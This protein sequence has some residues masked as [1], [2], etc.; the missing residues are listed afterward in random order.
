MKIRNI[1]P[2]SVI[3]INK[4][5]QNGGFLN[6][7]YT[8]ESGMT[9][10]AVGK[11]EK[12]SGDVNA[13]EEDWNNFLDMLGETAMPDS[14]LQELELKASKEVDE[15]VTGITLEMAAHPE[16]AIELAGELGKITSN[17]AK[18][19]ENYLDKAKKEASAAAKLR[20]LFHIGGIKMFT[21]NGKTSRAIEIPT[22]EKRS[23]NMKTVTTKEPFLLFSFYKKSDNS[24]LKYSEV[25]SID[26]K[27]VKMSTKISV[28][29][30]ANVFNDI[31][32]INDNVLDKMY[33]DG[34]EVD[35]TGR[36]HSSMYR[37]LQVTCRD[38]KTGICD[39]LKEFRDKYKKVDKNKKFLK[40]DIDNLKDHYK[41]LLK[42]IID[43][44]SIPNGYNLYL[45]IQSNTLQRRT[46][47]EK[48]LEDVNSNMDAL[49]GNYRE[50]N[51]LGNV[52]FTN[53]L[54]TIKVP[55]V[56]K[57]AEDEVEPRTVWYV[58]SILGTNIE[59]P[60]PSGA[61]CQGFVSK[62]IEHFVRQSQ[63]KTSTK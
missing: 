22:A 20:T 43:N 37:L 47:A 7:H 9:N 55:K 52:Y 19:I 18:I 31:F 44:N 16:K 46:I 30:E 21:K 41:K 42:V 28:L 38:D 36:N 33:K 2:N 14:K 15:K 45:N 63:D 8:D 59:P 53:I 5:K 49:T 61:W 57:G 13:T 39:T 11:V 48:M 34:I 58:E 62:Q 54:G 10:M 25:K 6:I 4:I 17:K 40:K 23:R 56:K 50:I 1:S 32:A 24:P 27:E 60:K 3:R 51:S 26:F 35:T 12:E 29:T